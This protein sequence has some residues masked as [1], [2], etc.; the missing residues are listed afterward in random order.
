LWVDTDRKVTSNCYG[1]VDYYLADALSRL[2][3]K[4]RV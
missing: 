4:S 2:R 3:R 1:E